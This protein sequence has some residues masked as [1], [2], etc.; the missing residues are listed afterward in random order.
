MR[1]CGRYLGL[2]GHLLVIGTDNPGVRALSFPNL[3]LKGKAEKS[4]NRSLL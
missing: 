3:I 4:K 1:H 2:V